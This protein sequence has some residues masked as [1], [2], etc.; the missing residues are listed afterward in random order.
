MKKYIQPFLYA[1][2]LFSISLSSCT[3]NFTEINTDPNNIPFALPEQLLAPAL[4]QVM[5][6]NMTRN[7]TFNNEL[8]QVTVNQSD[9]DIT[10]FRYD[11]KDSYSDYLYNGWYTQLTNI[12]DIY[13]YSSEALNYNASYMGI[14][15]TLQSWIYSMLTDSYGDIPFS[16]SNKGKSDNIIEPKFDTQKDI[17]D[18]IFA[19]LDSANT[20]LSKGASITAASDPVFN[21]D[22]AKWRK[23][24]NSLYLRLLLR[25]SG[26]KEVQPKVVAKIQEII[27]SSAKYPLMASN[28]D[29]AVLRWT[30]DG[31]YVSPFMNTRP[32]DFR[33]PSICSFF[34]DH[35]VTWSDPRIN[36]PEYGIGGVNRLGLAPISGNY[37]GVHSGYIPG[38]GEAK[39]SYFYATDSKIG[40]AAPAITMQT[41]PK[42]GLIMNYAEL[43]F[44]LAECVVKGW[45]NGDA[46]QYYKNGIE[47]GIKYWIPEY[48][49]PIEDYIAGA[50]IQWNS[51]GT[52]DE[53]MEQIG[54]Q[55]YYVLLWAD[56]EQWFE[57]RRTGHPILEKG[58]GL[59]NGGIMPARMKYPIYVRATNPTNYKA[60]IQRQG[61]D[62]ISTQVWWQKP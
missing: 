60:A 19:N 44:I 4:T 32:Q 46:E 62:E 29:N 7:R 56:L 52:F 28:D 21:G 16:E 11:F 54:L 6:Y 45:I 48:N 49:V 12:K 14:S 22:I 3:K 47:S 9:A 57:Y 40:T 59:K 61:P 5:T 42:T 43:Q 55:K 41:E 53:K 31:A 39:G 24:S 27:G 15:L 35:L 8:M 38:Q 2:L 10:V 33:V 58:P 30:G 50:D 23:F 51:N 34:I 26:K 17:Y 13:R 20:L 18:S 36:A 37:V 25:V 1:S